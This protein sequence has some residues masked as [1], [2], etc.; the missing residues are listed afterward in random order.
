MTRL[1]VT[2]PTGLELQDWAD[3]VTL[4]LDRFLL[5]GRIQA[6]DWQTWG[7]NL[8]NCVALGGNTLPDPY[9]FDAWEDWADRLC[10]ALG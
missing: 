7:V 8:L 1:A 10:E 2:R 3:A 5:L 9:Q 6:D 4:D